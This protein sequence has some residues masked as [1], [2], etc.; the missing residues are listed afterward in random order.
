MLWRS[1]VSYTHL[2]VYKR[3]TRY[4]LHVNVASSKALELGGIKKGFVPPVDNTVEFDENGEPTGR[5]WDQAAADLVTL[6]PDKF[7]SYEARKDAVED[8]YKRQGQ[9]GL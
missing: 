1:P 5:L 7:E 8:V 6:I 2:D 3:Q 9:T 4:C